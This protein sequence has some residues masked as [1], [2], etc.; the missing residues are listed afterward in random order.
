MFPPIELRPPEQ[1]LLAEYAAALETGWSPNTTRDV[2]DEQLATIRTDADA[3]L[4]EF[5]ERDGRT[6]TLP[7][8]LVVPRLPGPVFW[9]FDGALCGAINLRYQPGTLDLPP[10]ISG[11]IGFAV[12]P[13]KRRRGIASAALRL[14]LPVARARGLERVLLTC[15]EDNLASCRVIEGAGGIYTGSE[16]YAVDGV[17]KRQ[18]W[19][20]TG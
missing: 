15:D 16:P 17:A 13:W 11:H 7:G 4:A 9:I 20:A 19:V 18:Y 2:S 3:F 14:M 8:G 1:S 6:I 12:V 10:H 5:D